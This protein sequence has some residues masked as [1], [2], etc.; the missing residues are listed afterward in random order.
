MAIPISEVAPLSVSRSYR[1]YYSPF[2]VEQLVQLQA[3]SIPAASSSDPSRQPQPLSEH[4]INHLRQLACGF[5]ERTGQRIGF[6]RRTIATAQSLYHRFHLHFPLRDFSYQDVA[7]ASILVASKLED[8]LKKLRDIQIAAFQVLNAT[9]ESGGHPVPTEGDP[10][11]QEQHRPQLIGIERLI[12]QTICFNFTLHK[13]LVPPNPSAGGDAPPLSESTTAASSRDLFSHLVRLSMLLPS[14]NVPS[15]STSTSAV[16]PPDPKQLTYLAFLLATDLYRTLAP[17]SYPPHTCAAACLR[18]AYY[19]YPGD[20]FEENDL[21]DLIGIEWSR[22]TESNDQDLDDVA[23]MLLNLLISL[24]PS[25]PPSAVNSTIST[26]SPATPSSQPSPSESF[27]LVT[28]PTHRSTTTTNERD[29]QLIQTGVPNTFSHERFVW[30]NPAGTPIV[31]GTGVASSTMT[32][33]FVLSVDEL[34]QVKIRVRETGQLRRRKRTLGTKRVHREDGSRE[35]DLEQEESE[36]VFASSSKRWRSL[37]GS[38]ERGGGGVRELERLQQEA[39]ERFEDRLEREREKVLEH[40]E[41]ASRLTAE[42]R[43]RDKLERKEKRERS[44]PASIRYMF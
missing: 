31:L 35:D 39:H 13:S 23:Q 8:T 30:T 17:L 15:T 1:P 36:D 10:H 37:A 44:K 5:I 4:R 20:A 11:T 27:T 34:R 40:S 2:E 24:C 33:G 26:F 21:E 41:A 3:T 25:P 38:G 12:L 28:N 42:E 19:L 32:K 29:R 6:P 43:E 22:K 18:L 16:A 14:P 9:F 7:L